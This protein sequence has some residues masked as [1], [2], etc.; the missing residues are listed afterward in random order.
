MEFAVLNLG[1][2]TE[3]I[4]PAGAAENQCTGTC[5]TV[6]TGMTCFG[7]VDSPKRLQLAACHALVRLLDLLRSIHVQ[8]G[9][10]GI[11]FVKQTALLY[12]LAYLCRTDH[13]VAEVC[14]L[15]ETPAT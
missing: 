8:D 3:S 6:V 15:L 7:S 2:Y 12:P 1:R 13:R 4:A 14:T 9:K 5:M 10:K 11:V